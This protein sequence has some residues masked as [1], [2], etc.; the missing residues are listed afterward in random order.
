MKSTF[1]EGSPQG[2]AARRGQIGEG[3]EKGMK[4]RRNQSQS[5]HPLIV[6]IAGISGKNLVRSVAGEDHRDSGFLKC[7]GQ[8]ER[9]DAR[10]VGV[11]LVEVVSYLVEK[12]EDVLGTA[13]GRL[14]VATSKAQSDLT[15]EICIYIVFRAP[16]ANFISKTKSARRGSAVLA[17]QLTDQSCQNGTV[18]ST[19]KKDP[20]RYIGNQA[21]LN[22]RFDTLTHFGLPTAE[23]SVL[24]AGGGFP[25][26]SQ[27]D[28]AILKSQ[29]VAGFQS[30]N[31]TE[32]RTG[33]GSVAEAQVGSKTVGVY[34]IG[35]Q[36]VGC[37]RSQFGAKEKCRSYLAV[38][39]G[40][41]SHPVPGEYKA[42]MA[43]VPEGE[44][45]HAD[46]LIQKWRPEYR[47]AVVEDL[48]ISPGTKM[49]ASLLE[50]GAQLLEIVDLA[51]EYENRR[52]GALLE[53]L[54]CLL[55]EID[56]RKSTMS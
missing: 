19:R 17:A 10:R 38:V 51:V 12:F 46:N 53:R 4:G 45:K 11:G 20:Q 15:R 6:T 41:L 14:F 54:G 7:S 36:W 31:R 25:V 52:V 24:R 28:P 32:Y 55:G 16:F 34:R 21:I 26:S 13:K 44:G 3:I 1:P 33:A 8:Y 43:G 39:E 35:N 27:L 42:A 2:L 23:A 22:R 18:H 29:N 50:L 37:Q 49:D 5:F 56:D 40:L 30:L 47:E 9:I 48:G